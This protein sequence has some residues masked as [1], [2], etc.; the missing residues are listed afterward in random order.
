[1]VFIS[2]ADM[3]LACNVFSDSFFSTGTFLLYKFLQGFGRCGRYMCTQNFYN[4]IMVVVI[5]EEAQ[6]LTFISFRHVWLQSQ[7]QITSMFVT[8]KK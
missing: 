6:F 8:Q 7:I 1:M 3:V 5:I 2:N 4:K